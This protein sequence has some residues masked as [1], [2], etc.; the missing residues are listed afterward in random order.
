MICNRCMNTNPLVNAKGDHC[1]TCGCPVVR[2]FGSFDTLP[3]VE[4]KPDSKIPP[5][6]VK[7]LLKQD[8]PLAEV[9]MPAA[10]PRRQQ[11]DQWSES[12]GGAEQVLSFNAEQ[13]LPENDLFNMRLLEWMS[14]QLT[15]E[16]YEPVP[17]D[18]NILVNMH[19]EE[20]F[21]VDMTHICPS[22]P[23]RY[24]K[25]MVPDVAITMCENCC[26]F[27]I[28]DEYEFAYIEFGHCSF[29]KHVEKDK[30]QK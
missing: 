16:N 18:A 2:N 8:P 3:L 5:L 7:Q 15:P 29:C 21:I 10:K 20:V 13:D 6:K 24:F 19:N 17:V 14:T 11:N 30:G 22:Y 4:F 28:L 9:R 26:K 12:M 25:N 27:F 23:L 1:I